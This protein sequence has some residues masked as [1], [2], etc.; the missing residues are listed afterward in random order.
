MDPQQMQAALAHLDQQNVAF[1]Q[2]QQQIL[3]AQ[4]QLN[5]LVANLPNNGGGG[6]QQG[7][8]NVRKE[9]EKHTNKIHPW[10]SYARFWRKL[11]TCRYGHERGIK[12]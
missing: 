5:G 11:T 7:V 12:R 8:R 2:Q 6:Q 1:Q 4:A 9:L 10:R 3:D